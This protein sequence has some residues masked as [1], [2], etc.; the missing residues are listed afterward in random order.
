MSCVIKKNIDHHN[1]KFSLPTISVDSGGGI[2]FNK[3]S[4]LD[5]DGESL[6]ESGAGSE[7]FI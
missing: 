5:D 1:P 3:L 7:F 6:A 2:S 4:L